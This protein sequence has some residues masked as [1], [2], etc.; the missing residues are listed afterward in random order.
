MNPVRNKNILVATLL[1]LTACGP[2]V[3]IGDSG[4]APQRYTL[5][6]APSDTIAK[7]LPVLR[8]EELE[9]AADLASNRIAVRVGTQEV[10][11]LVGGIWTDKPARLMR[12]LLAD[13]LRARSQGVVLAANQPEVQVAYRVTGRLIAFQAEGAGAIATHA[14]VS[15]EYFIL[16]GTKIIASRSFGQRRRL[17]SDRANDVT[18]SL[19]QAANDMNADASAWVASIATQ[20][21]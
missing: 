1:L 4:P 8:I 20:A 13:H 14:Q 17:I 9:T 21:R 11:Y 7:A 12:N 16:Q 5:T 3:K 10:R 6:A 2:L 15:A 19:N 18:A